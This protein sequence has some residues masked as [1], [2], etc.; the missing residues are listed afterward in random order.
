MIGSS[1]ARHL[2]ERA[3]GV[4]LVGPD[5]PTNPRE[6]DGAFGSFHDAS[7]ITR[8]LDPNPHLAYF[9]KNSLQR[10]RQLEEESGIS[11]YHEIGCLVLAPADSEFLSSIDAV[12]KSL[13]LKLESLS[14]LDVNNRLQ[15]L[16]VSAHFAGRLQQKDAGF[17]NPRRF[18]DAQTK[19]AI[20]NG[21]RIV[22]QEV[23]AL[24][25]AKNGVSVKFES[26]ETILADQVLVAAGAY[27]NLSALLSRPVTISLVG[28]TLLFLE[29]NEHDLGVFSDFPSVICR[30]AS[31]CDRVYFFPPIKY[32]DGK[33]YL[34]IGAGIDNEYPLQSREDLQAWFRSSGDSKM[35]KETEQTLLALI[36]DLPFSTTYT[37]TCVNYYT[38][39]GLPFIG[40]TSVPRVWVAAGCNGS[41]AKSSDEYG[42]IAARAM[43]AGGWDYEIGPEQFEPRYAA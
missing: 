6:H 27:C 12:A 39:T 29:V 42:L 5:E 23:I 8:V 11:F 14:S 15:P 16:K 41:G 3:D 19:V 35:A 7:R 30:G 10:A 38:G 2:S 34:K 40:K 1:A 17:I 13:D 20:R 24:E 25:P 26:S 33:H 36:P 4:L 31:P 21:T 28:R 22:R 37:K 43:L 32:P 18:V 9:A